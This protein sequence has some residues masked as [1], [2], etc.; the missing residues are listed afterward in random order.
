MGMLT[1]YEIKD[2]KAILYNQCT[3]RS[4]SERQRQQ[5]VEKWV[6]EARKVNKLRVLGAVRLLVKGMP[7]IKKEDALNALVGEE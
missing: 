4:R 6:K 2:G 7:R 3:D 5:D 1:D